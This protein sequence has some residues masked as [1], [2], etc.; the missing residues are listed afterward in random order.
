MS[1]LKTETLRVDLDTRAYDIHIGSGLIARAG[2]LIKPVLRQPRVIVISDRNVA[3]LYMSKL[4]RSLKRAGIATDKICSKV[5]PAC[6]VRRPVV[7]SAARKR[8][9]PAV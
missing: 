8:S 1:E 4:L 5:T 7:Q 6:A 2:D 9:R 3:P